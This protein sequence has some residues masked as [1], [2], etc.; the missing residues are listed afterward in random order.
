[1]ALLK[2]LEIIIYFIAFLA[3]AF[4]WIVGFAFVAMLENQERE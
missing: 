2:I 4:V 1:M 3:A